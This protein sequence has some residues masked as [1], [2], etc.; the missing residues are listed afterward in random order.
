MLQTERAVF[1]PPFFVGLEEEKSFTAKP[2]GASAKKRFAQS[3]LSP[4]A[5]GAAEQRGN[6]E[7]IAASAALGGRR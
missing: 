6:I 4:V 2:A 7:T 1:G 5:K 3:R